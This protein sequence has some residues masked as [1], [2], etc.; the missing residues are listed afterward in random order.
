MI[1]TTRQNHVG[2]REKNERL[3]LVLDDLYA[4]KND[5]EQLLDQRLR[6]KKCVPAKELTSENNLLLPHA[7]DAAGLS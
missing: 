3:L 4:C 7:P 2:H 6:S 5:H 1:P